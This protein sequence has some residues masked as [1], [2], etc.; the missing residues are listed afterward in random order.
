MPLLNKPPLSP[1]SLSLLS[2]LVN[3][4][5]SG[6]PLIIAVIARKSLLS[7]LSLLSLSSLSLLAYSTPQS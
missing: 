1:L 7:L 5:S 4:L 3:R 6:Q 2:S